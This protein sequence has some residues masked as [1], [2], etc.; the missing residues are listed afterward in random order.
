[1]FRNEAY[2]PISLADYLLSN[3]LETPSSRNVRMFVFSGRLSV[4]PP[5]ESA[6]PYPLPGRQCFEMAVNAR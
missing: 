5:R 4:H 6:P 1:M 3:L 2:S